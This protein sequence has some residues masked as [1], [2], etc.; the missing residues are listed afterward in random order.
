MRKSITIL[1]ITLIMSATVT[2]A[3]SLSFYD[4]SDY[5]WAQGAVYRLAEKGVIQGVAPHTYAPGSYVSRAE[6]CTLL[7]RIFKIGGSGLISYPD[8]SADSY[9]YES[10]AAFKALGILKD[11]PDGGFH[12]DDAVTR[13]ETMRLTGFLLERFGFAENP[14]VSCLEA[15]YDSGLISP[16]NAGYC[17]LLIENGYI[18]GDGAGQLNPSGYLTRAE[19][20]V[21]LDRIYSKIF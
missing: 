11:H 3:S 21:I 6:L 16:E 13:E 5:G 14:D 4:L 19:T 8:V 20:A 10:S 1:L 15:F 2:N 9:Y 12:P 17:S 18:T 7:H